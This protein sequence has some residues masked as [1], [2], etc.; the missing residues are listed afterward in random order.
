MRGIFVG[1]LY[2]LA[3]EYKDMRKAILAA[4]TFFFAIAPL[5]PAMAQTK[6]FA[7]LNPDCL[8]KAY[9]ATDVPTIQGFECLMANILS[10]AI[11]LVGIVAFVMFLVGGFQYLTAGSNAKGT[12]QGKNSITFAIVGIVI[13]LAS[14]LLVNIIS[15]ITGVSIIKQFSTQ[16]QPTPKP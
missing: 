5:S 3:L 6:S 2:R 11:T 4:V 15:G 7:S 16:L 1:V 8:G 10:S 12:E 14:I 13:A 9:G